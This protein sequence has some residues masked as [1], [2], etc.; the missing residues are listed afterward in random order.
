VAPELE[1]SVSTDDT[2]RDQAERVTLGAMLLSEQAIDAVTDIG[3]RSADF[4]RP[5]HATI[6]AKIIELWAGNQPVDPYI[7]ATALAESG[8]LARV[9]GADYLHSCYSAVPTAANA[10][11]YARTV[12]DHAHRRHLAEAAVTLSRVAE[13]S[14]PGARAARLAAVRVD[15]DAID[16]TTPGEAG[17]VDRMLAELLDTSDLDNIPNLEPLIPDLL[18]MDT[19]ARMNGP[20]GH[21]KSFMALDMAGAVGT[22]AHWHG[23]PVRQGIVVYLVAEGSRGVRKRVRAW[24]QHH[25]RKMTG[26]KF[27][28]RPV[29][30][31]SPEWQTLTEVCKRLRPALVVVDTQARVTV[32]VEENSA[33]EMGRVVDRLEGLRTASGAC[34]LLIHHKGLNGDHGRG[35]TAVKGAMQTEVTVT[36]DDK[37]VTLAVDKQKD[38]EEIADLCFRLE[39]VPLD[40]EAEEDGRPVTSAVLL[41]DDTPSGA[42]GRG[43]TGDKL[44]PAETKLLNAV[45]ALNVPASNIEVVDRVVQMTGHGLTRPTASKGLN[46]LHSLGLIERIPPSGHH[47]VARWEH[48]GDR[49]TSLVTP[50]CAVPNRLH[51]AHHPSETDISAGQQVCPTD[52]V[53]PGTGGVPGVP[54][55][56]KGGTPGTPCPDDDLW[57]GFD[58]QQTT[59]C[60][61]CYRPHQQPPNTPCDTCQEAR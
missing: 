50:P 53:T 31:T 60:P 39:S 19:L 32:G 11:Y 52:L 7:L 56:Y 4:Y 54:P 3:L 41:V 57:D 9:G 22:G 29:Q 21:G 59:A 24:E 37:A 8:D 33:T 48:V 17:A 12:A 20:S 6:Y 45:N 10:G 42:S 14:D 47:D 18:Y 2:E 43:K 16:G 51:L 61:R 40:G 34:V 58:A 38:S 49:S 15:L 26:V 13:I 27:L 46:R 55:P 5:Q 30:A 23:R 1:G 36:K 44:S 35:S 25:A 28:P